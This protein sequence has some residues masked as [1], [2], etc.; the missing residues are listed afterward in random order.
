[1][2]AAFDTYQRYVPDSPELPKIAYR[3]ARIY[4]EY[5]HYEKAAGLFAA[6]VARYPEDP[7][8]V[9]AINLQLDALNT[10]GRSGEACTEAQ[11]YAGGPQ[12]A[13]DKELA[14]TLQALRRGC[15]R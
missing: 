4:Y 1:M 13:R 3:K 9:F 5:G 11:R 7:L 8:A 10:L 15:A 2:L 14:R 12:A 6:L